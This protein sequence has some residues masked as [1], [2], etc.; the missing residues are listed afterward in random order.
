MVC[1]LHSQFS[2]HLVQHFDA[3]D[4]KTFIDQEMIIMSLW[5]MLVQHI[6]YKCPEVQQC[7]HVRPTTNSGIIIRGALYERCTPGSKAQIS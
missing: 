2:N 1:N 3:H 6:N 4:H 5:K 7:G